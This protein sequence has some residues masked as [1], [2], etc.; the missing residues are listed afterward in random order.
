VRY[1]SS[2]KCESATFHQDPETEPPKITG[3]SQVEICISTK[4]I[5]SK[6]KIKAKKIKRK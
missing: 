5:I 3:V 6:R 1:P 2:K 4:K